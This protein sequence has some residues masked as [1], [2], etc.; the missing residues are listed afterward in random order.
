M[1][2]AALSR[3]VLQRFSRSCF[4]WS[5]SNESCRD[6]RVFLFFF[7]VTPLDVLVT[8]LPSVE[9]VLTAAVFV[10]TLTFSLP[11]GVLMC[12]CFCC[13]SDVFLAACIPCL[14]DL[15]IVGVDLPTFAFI[16]GEAKEQA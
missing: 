3:I 6:L 12:F 1:Q 11:L 5:S 8:P 13:K 7:K 10:L 15:E 14:T 9:A 16:N 2:S 4:P